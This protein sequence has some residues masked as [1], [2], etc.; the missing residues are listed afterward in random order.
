MHLS[1]GEER[2]RGVHLEMNDNPPFPR[3]QHAIRPDCVLFVW[4]DPFLEPEERGPLCDPFLLPGW[5]FSFFVKEEWKWA[6]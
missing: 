2:V 6:D 3:N 5:A 4:C 1:G